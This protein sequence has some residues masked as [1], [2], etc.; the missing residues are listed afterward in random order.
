MSCLGIHYAVE[1]EVARRLLAAAGE[2]EW[3][4]LLDELDEAWGGREDDPWTRQ[5]GSAWDAIHRVLTDGT[6]KPGIGPLARFVL[7]GRFV[8][9]ARGQ[10]IF[11]VSPEESKES[12]VAAAGIDE[13]WFRE[14]FFRMLPRKLDRLSLKCFWGWLRDELSLRT[15]SWPVD[16]ESFRDAWGWFQGMPEFFGR[17][18]DA[19]RWVVVCVSQ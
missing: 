11:V 9:E 18:G 3:G 8:G 16:E 19:G 4:E 6:L 1:P 14:R 15:P 13:A 5:M 7:G 10:C 12:E 17:A 2:A